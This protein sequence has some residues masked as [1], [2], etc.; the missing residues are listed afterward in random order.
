MARLVLAARGGTLGAASLAFVLAGLA[1]PAPASAWLQYRTSE[2]KGCGLRWHQP[3]IDY[4]VDTAAPEGLAHADFLAA[5]DGAFRGWSQVQCGLCTS[6]VA[7]GCAP[8]K[9]AP[10]A[11]GLEMHLKGVA[12][13]TPVGATCTES[14]AAGTCIQV[15]S[16]G[17]F[18]S[19]AQGT[20]DAWIYGQFVFA[21]TV[22]TF[23]RQTGAIADADILL[24]DTG[25][26]FCIG[27]CK[28][29][30]HNVCNTL[31]HE[32]GH[33]LGLDHSHDAQAT[34]FSTA[35]SGEVKKCSLLDDDR[36]GA[37]VVYRTACSDQGCPEPAGIDELL[38]AAQRPLLPGESVAATCSGGRRASPDGTFAVLLALG[39]AWTVARG[40]RW[41]RRPR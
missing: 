36:T 28:P 25:A 12:P 21:L 31:T 16:N 14:N 8:E 15:A 4:L 2:S 26:D 30:Q 10:Q 29:G 23:N 39:L 37:C 1:W 13:P 32:A 24:D 34:M 35:P 7:P 38:G 3:D 20:P 41:W 40:Q 18:V 17:N 5:V 19:V 33:F 22:L 9:C 27:P 11:L 6:K